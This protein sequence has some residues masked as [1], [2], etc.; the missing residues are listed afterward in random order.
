M[1]PRVPLVAHLPL[2]EDVDQAD[3]ADAQVGSRANETEA[4]VV[5]DTAVQFPAL[6]DLVQAEEQQPDHH[7]E[8]ARPDEQLDEEVGHADEVVVSLL[9]KKR[10]QTA[11]SQTQTHREHRGGK[12]L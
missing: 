1:Y 2:T 5:A 4:E 10:N 11:P 8:H 12:G 6:L 3:N 7:E 9:V